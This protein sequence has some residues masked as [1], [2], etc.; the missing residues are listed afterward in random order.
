MQLLKRHLLI[1]L[2]YFIIYSCTHDSSTTDED[3]RSNAMHQDR[4]NILWLVSEDNSPETV[5][6]YGDPAARTPNIDRLAQQG[7]VFRHAFANSPVCAVARSALISGMHSPSPGLHLM[8]SRIEVPEYLEDAFYPRL[9]QLAGYYT[10]NNAKTDYNVPEPHSRF[11]DESGNQAHYKNR[12]SD[13]PFFAVFNN[14]DPHESRMFMDVMTEEPVTNPDDITLPPFHPDIPEIRRSWAHYYDLNSKMDEW[15]GEMLAELEELGEADNTIV[16]YYSDHGGVLPRSKRFLYH[17]GTAVAFVVYLP[18]K[19]QHLAPYEPGSCVDELVSFVDFPATVLELAELDIPEH[20]Q[21]RPFMGHRPGEEPGTVFLYR[22]RMVQ[23]FDM[24]R[25]VFDGEYRYIRNYMPHRPNGQYIHYPFRMQ[26]MQAWYHAWANGQTTPEQSLFW[27]PQPPEELYHTAV[28]K[29]E[30]NNL[31]HDPVYAGKL[32]ELREATREH[33]LRIRDAGFI[34]EDMF[35]DLA[36]EQTLYEYTQSEAYPLERLVELAEQATS[37]NPEYLPLLELAMSD[38]FPP[39]RYWGALGCLV[40]GHDSYA[41]RP[42]LETL[43]DD[44]FASIRVMAAEALSRL[45][46]MDLAIATLDD[47]LDSVRED[48]LLYA[49][50]ALAN[51]DV[52]DQY[53]SSLL[54]KLRPIAEDEDRE[55]RGAFNFSRR[56]AN[57]LV[58]KWTEDDY[59]PI[60]E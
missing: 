16:M 14:H 58:K 12:A 5:G 35:V 49:V 32:N 4:P 57:Y 22:D 26:S 59:P 50:N 23:T 52:H 3:R 31:A 36:S 37:R 9:F 25:G 34:P 46:D 17:T 13:Q 6:V 8:R 18:E 28:D 30:V 29:W 38:P 11:W 56:T 54:S 41:M 27:L 60:F 7:L 39:F 10:T 20:Y 40:L 48:E 53:R 51:M 24:Q 33:V 15:V 19:W 55:V 42:V 45:G 44:D 2:L 21:G 43:L 47:I 1:I